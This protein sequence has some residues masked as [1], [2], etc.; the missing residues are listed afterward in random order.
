[1]IL[2]W[3]V[4]CR[5]QFLAVQVKATSETGAARPRANTRSYPFPLYGSMGTYF[6]T[7]TGALA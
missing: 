4:P 1:V 5:A 7:V 3:L 2:T 6:L